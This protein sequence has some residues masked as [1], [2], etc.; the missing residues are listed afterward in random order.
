MMR[1]THAVILSVAR[2]LVR[3]PSMLLLDEVCCPLVTPCT[4]MSMA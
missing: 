4:C 2:A 3:N 1:G